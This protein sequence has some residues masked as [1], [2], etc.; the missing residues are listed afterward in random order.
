MTN[1][2]VPKRERHKWLKIRAH[3]Y[4]CLKCGCLKENEQ[5]PEGGFRRTWWHRPADGARVLMTATPYCARG[6]WTN[7]LLARAA[8]LESEAG[9]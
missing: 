6:E 5:R 7:E 9:A 4:V 8:T 2:D 3:W 1:A